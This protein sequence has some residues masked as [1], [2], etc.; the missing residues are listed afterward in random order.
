MFAKCSFLEKGR[1][2]GKSARKKVLGF[3]PG[4]QRLSWGTVHDLGALLFS[5]L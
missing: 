1:E 5:V 2:R 3:P 4:M